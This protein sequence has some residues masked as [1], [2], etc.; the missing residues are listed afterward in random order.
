MFSKWFFVE[1]NFLFKKFFGYLLALFLTTWGGPLF[2]D[3]F[4]DGQ[5]MEVNEQKETCVVQFVDGDINEQCP[6]TK[7]HIL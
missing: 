7:M 2:R 4:Y 1:K 3:M 5:I 6:W